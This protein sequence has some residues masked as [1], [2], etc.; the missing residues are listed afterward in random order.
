[1]L[2]AAAAA[3]YRKSVAAASAPV[4]A[5]AAAGLQLHPSDWGTACCLWPEQL[6]GALNH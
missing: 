1:M 3:A 5:A 4:T 6:R 2:L